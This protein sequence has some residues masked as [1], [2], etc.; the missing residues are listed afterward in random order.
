M[1]WRSNRRWHFMLSRKLVQSSRCSAATVLFA[2]LTST[3]SIFNGK[4][5]NS[6]WLWNL[7]P[8]NLHTGSL[9]LY[10]QEKQS[11]LHGGQGKSLILHF[12]PAF[13][14][15]HTFLWWE[16]DQQDQTEITSS[17]FVLH[18]ANFSWRWS[19]PFIT[20][21]AFM[22]EVVLV[23]DLSRR[24]SRLRMIP[25]ETSWSKLTRRVDLLS[26]A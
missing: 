24:D 12:Y 22:S 13:F 23:F 20:G 17:L 26:V 3:S 5:A 14:S 15:C 2:A 1:E 18:L 16:I 7:S 25:R 19:A 4:K 10:V 8:S 6:P 21:F 9:S 11:K